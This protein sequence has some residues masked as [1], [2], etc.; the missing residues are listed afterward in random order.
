MLI[1]FSNP[2][3]YH[4]FLESVVIVTTG[5]IMHLNSISIIELKYTKLP[6]LTPNAA[7]TLFVFSSLCVLSKLRPLWPN[8]LRK[9]Q[10]ILIFIVEMALILYAMDFLLRQVWLPCLKLL[11][12]ICHFLGQYVIVANEDFLANNAPRISSWIRDDGFYIIRFLLAVVVFIFMLDTTGIW[13][14]CQTKN[15]CHNLQSASPSATQFST[16]IGGSAIYSNHQPHAVM[17][18]DLSRALLDENLP[19]NSQDF[20]VHDLPYVPQE[21][22]LNL[23][24]RVGARRRRNPVRNARR[25]SSSNEKKIILNNG[26]NECFC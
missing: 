16:H 24:H 20:N 18:D 15:R 21:D 26:D 12:F 11:N 17:S 6:M 7:S 19:R 10:R 4:K 3:E 2:Q 14:L 5:V 22:L 23:G 9:P 8:V 13:E 25:S 1:N